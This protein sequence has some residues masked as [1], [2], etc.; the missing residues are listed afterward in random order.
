MVQDLTNPDSFPLLDDYLNYL[1]TIKGR[2]A[3]TVKEYRYDLT[4]FFR[5]MRKRRG[6]FPPAL[7]IEEVTLRTLDVDFIKSITLSDCYAFLF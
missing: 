4:L 1:E 2:A 3:G 6:H 7:P 5:Y